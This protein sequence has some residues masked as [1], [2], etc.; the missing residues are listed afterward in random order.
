VGKKAGKQLGSRLGAAI[1]RL[2]DAKVPLDATL[3]QQ[4]FTRIAGKRYPVHGGDG[5][6]GAF[7]VVGWSAGRNSTIWPEFGKQPPLS[8][9]GLTDEGYPINYGSSYVMAMTFTDDGP[10]ARALLT[11]SQS[12]EPDSK[13]VADQTAMLGQTKLRPVLFEDA[14][15]DADPNLEVEEVGQ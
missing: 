10:K 3:G 11:Y 13:W 6:I 5:G 12:A 1:K 2:T 14:E 7:N 9:A 15:I 8:D 4:Q